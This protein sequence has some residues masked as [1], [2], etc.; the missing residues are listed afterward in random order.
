MRLN[1]LLT[2]LLLMVPFFFQSCGSSSSL[3][4]YN[5]TKLQSPLDE[6]YISPKKIKINANK[7]KTIELEDGSSLKIPKDAFVDKNG[8]LITGE[9]ELSYRQYNDA[10]DIIASGIPMQYQQANGTM[11]QLESAGMFELKGTAN[12]QPVFIAPDKS[13]ET[14]IA[15][16]KTGNYD[17]YYLNPEV[18]KNREQPYNWEKLTHKADNPSSKPIKGL[19]SFQVKLNTELHPELE[20]L[21]NIQWQLALPDAQFNPK[22]TVNSIFKDEDWDD[23]TISQPKFILKKAHTIS[24]CNFF[25]K[26]HFIGDKI[27]FQSWNQFQ[28]YDKNLQKIYE[29]TS[30]DI[31]SDDLLIAQDHKGIYK[32]LNNNLET[33][34]ELGAFSNQYNNYQYNP[35][36]EKLAYTSVNSNDPFLLK[37]LVIVDKQ[38][39]EKF[40]KSYK[41]KKPDS[42]HN[43][44]HR[45]QLEKLI[46]ESIYKL[47][48]LDWDG[49]LIA[50]FDK[51]KEQCTNNSS[52][53]YGELILFKE[54]F[55]TGNRLIAWNW[56]KNESFK[57]DDFNGFDLYS[58][59]FHATKNIILIHKKDS[60]ILWNIETG[61]KTKLA[62][63]FADFLEN[64]DNFI[65]LL[66]ENNFFQL[67]DLKGN[68]LF[69]EDL[70]EKDM[71][72]VE[73]LL[74]FSKNGKTILTSFVANK[75]I[76]LYDRTGKL[77][78]DFNTYDKKIQQAF[79]YKDDEIITFSENGELSYWNTKGKLLGKTQIKEQDFRI[80]QTK[81]DSSKFVSYRTDIKY[82]DIRGQLLINFGKNFVLNSSPN[83]TNQFIAFT[84]VNGKGEHIFF[85]ASTPRD[86]GIYQLTLSNRENCLIS[87]VYIDQA[88]MLIIEAYRL[89]KKIRITKEKKK[90]IEDEKL[91]RS[92]SINNFGI[93]NW[94]RFYKNDPETQ[95]RLNP[96][97]SADKDNKDKNKT[98]FLITG[99]GRNAVIRYTSSTLD[100]FS[101]NHTMYNQLFVTLS[102]GRI[103][104]FENEDFK[105]LNIEKLKKTK[106]HYFRMKVYN[107]VDGLKHLKKLTK[108]EL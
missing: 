34:K 101:F 3:Q 87:Y 11:Q 66:N 68:L 28:L 85:D 83:T 71:S 42:R 29:G 4:N 23:L 54:N 94:D 74:K 21:K 108:S 25:S 15:S 60:P 64:E 65:A 84:K 37:D 12:G 82:W 7:E 105:K 99:T 44:E 93:Y 39:V 58:S 16:N 38:G 55:R 67:L 59:K 31:I 46:V 43:L 19:D 33:L 97:F 78:K 1:S 53:G 24:Q 40:R 92:F 13:I 62:E 79:F 45:V 104:I 26:V 35:K 95:I 47:E 72:F 52:T 56:K 63:G 91:I 89:K 76:K 70:L 57:D 10:A 6:V 81:E 107:R 103:A 36:T 50:S 18:E 48:V 96:S 106:K 90:A 100:N 41:I 77:I 102:D 73:D 20:P 9:V 98:V 51:E 2:L 32:L 17:F 8:K 5:Y 75:K 80:R 27:L 69:K 22:S 88:T 49:N 30:L 14:N 86:T 61:Q